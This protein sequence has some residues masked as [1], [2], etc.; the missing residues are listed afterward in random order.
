MSCSLDYD[1]SSIHQAVAKIGTLNS[2]ESSYVLLREQ[3]P[4]TCVSMDP[5][6]AS[7]G[8]NRF[9]MSQNRKYQ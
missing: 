6:L 4:E 7:G 2:I 3:F 8:I 5:A 1:Y 9:S